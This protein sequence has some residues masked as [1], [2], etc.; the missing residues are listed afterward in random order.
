MALICI[1]FSQTAPCSLTLSRLRTV[2]LCQEQ[3][4]NGWSS[5]SPW[6]QSSDLRS[7]AALCS[8][9]PSIYR[10]TI[11]PRL[12]SSAPVCVRQLPV[13]FPAISGPVKKLFHTSAGLRAQPAV[14]LWLLVKPLQKVTAIILGR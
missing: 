10:K 5:R 8:S 3:T 13:H 11:L 9:R 14:L 1:R 7:T 12:L 4:L 2:L 6:Y